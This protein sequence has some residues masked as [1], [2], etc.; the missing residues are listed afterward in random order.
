M[1]ER[2]R[3][4]PLVIVANRAPVHHARDASG[5]VQRVRS[6]SGLVTALE[7]LAEAVSA[8]WVAH[9]EPLDL[10]AA[11]GAGHVGVPETEPRY[12]V[13][14][15][16]VDANVYRGY[17]EGFA[18]EG[19]WP[20]CHAAGVEPV[21]RRRDYRDYR[22]VNRRFAD[23]VCGE[24]GTAAPA[25]LVQDYHFALAPR[26]IRQQM[27]SS[28]ILTFW[29]IPWPEP[30]TAQRCPWMQELLAGLLGSDVVGLQTPDDCQRFL[31]TVARLIRG[32]VVQG[33]AI[34]HDGRVIR[35]R[36]LPVGVQVDAA[37][38]LE[39]PEARVCRASV[40]GEYGVAPDAWLGVGIDRL[41]Y[42]KGIPEKFQAIEHLLEQR[43]DLHG[44]FAF[45]QVAEPSRAALPAYQRIRSTVGDIAAR[46]NRRFGRG[47]W[48]PIVVRDVHADSADVHRLYRAADLCFVNSL[49]DGMN[50][51][52]KEFVAA[53]DDERGVLLLSQCAGAS[54]QLTDALPVMPGRP[55]EAARQLEAALQMPAAEQQLRM[56]AMRAVVTASD[57]YWWANQLLLGVRSAWTHVE[58][59]TDRARV[60]LG[61]Q[62]MAATCGLPII[63]GIDRIPV[64]WASR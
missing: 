43:P 30:A 27:P 4:A 14:Y 22:A 9:G 31:Q 49:A 6:A 38:L 16:G 20:L 2:E 57:C 40:C 60:H 56:R 23:A 28:S 13:R 32:A 18:N 25:V 64:A 35:V 34:V 7:P 24:T 21:F 11:D 46:V 55:D 17:Y 53:R 58:R 52:A 37:A 8:T 42:S 54:Q 45:I 33:E 29:H 15:V 10:A 59:R 1:A 48:T 12:T 63:S 61:R 19:L 51:V 50:L 47:H 62:P 39:V 5:Q 44:R 36:A 41:D 3:R 26:M